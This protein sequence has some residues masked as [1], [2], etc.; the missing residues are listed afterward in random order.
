ME[1]FV[2][3]NM[4][5]VGTDVKNCLE[6]LLTH[7]NGVDFGF[8]KFEDDIKMLI[9]IYGD[10]SYEKYTI[11]YKE[12]IDASE[13]CGTVITK[14]FNGDCEVFEPSL[15]EK[16]IS[17][18]LMENEVE[19]LDIWDGELI[20][21]RNNINV[22]LNCIQVLKYD[23]IESNIILILDDDS[24]YEVDLCEQRIYEIGNK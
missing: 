15:E 23:H 24:K 20:D 19:K 3:N 9:W 10:N 22:P 7:N 4:N 12:G 14:M 13:I 8:A 16:Y 21:H 2:T 17:D 5:I 18:L 1:N 11:P 6:N